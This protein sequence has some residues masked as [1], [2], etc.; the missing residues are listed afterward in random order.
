MSKVKEVRRLTKESGQSFVR[1]VG[2][3]VMIFGMQLFLVLVIV[4]GKAIVI[5]IVFVIRIVMLMVILY[6]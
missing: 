4:F 2:C 5:V 1:G 3:R 6:W